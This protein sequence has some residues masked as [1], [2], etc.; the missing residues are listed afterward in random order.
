M[1]EYYFAGS[2]VIGATPLTDY[3]GNKIEGADCIPLMEQNLNKKS[4]KGR[5]LYNRRL[6]R[7]YNYAFFERLA[8]NKRCG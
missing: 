8:R 4:K 6:R 7:P 2:G 1:A 3:A 5:Y